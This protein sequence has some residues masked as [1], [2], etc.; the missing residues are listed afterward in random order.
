V[1]LYLIQKNMISILLEF[2]MNNKPPFYN[3]QGGSGY[4]MGDSV[5]QPNFQYA[6]Q[7]FSYLVKCCVTKGINLVGKYS[8]QSV[9][10]EESKT[11]PMPEDHI[12]GFLTPDCQQEI[13]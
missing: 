9:F 12:M 10:Q 13:F 2:V 7:L 4:R 5:Q 3:S 1:A 11:I 8:R 6:Y